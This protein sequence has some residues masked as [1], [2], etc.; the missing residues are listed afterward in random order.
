MPA[1]EVVGAN[2]VESVVEGAG[3]GLAISIM[4]VGTSGGGGCLRGKVI[5]SGKMSQIILPAGDSDRALGEA[6]VSKDGIKVS[7]WIVGEW[8]PFGSGPSA[9]PSTGDTLGGTRTGRSVSEEGVTSVEAEGGGLL[10]EAAGVDIS[11][12]HSRQERFSSLRPS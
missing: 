2:R 7:G 3:D 1:I 11:R 12:C 8:T 5:F 9:V 4:Y 10:E 6:I